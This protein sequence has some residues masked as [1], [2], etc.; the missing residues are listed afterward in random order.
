MAKGAGIA[1][2]LLLLLGHAGILK[3]VTSH[4][5]LSAAVA[6]AGVI[7]LVLAHLGLLGKMLAFRHGRVHES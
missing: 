4:L 5:K 3:Y 1:A 6:G 2:V 7:V